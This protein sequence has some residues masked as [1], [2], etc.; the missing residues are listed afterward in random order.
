MFSDAVRATWGGAA[1]GKPAAQK[2]AAK[3]EEPKKEAAK[4]GDDDMDLFGDDDEG[5]EVSLYLI[6]TQDFNFK[7]GSKKTYRSTESQGCRR[8]EGKA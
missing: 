6:G 4:G 2:P 1:G 7:L 5:D 8:Q 3:K